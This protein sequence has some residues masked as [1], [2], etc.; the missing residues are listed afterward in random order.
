LLIIT[1]LRRLRHYL[2]MVI[3]L[4]RRRSR[5]TYLHHLIC[6]LECE[7]DK[8]NNCIPSIH[9]YLYFIRH[10]WIL[11]ILVIH[12]YLRLARRWRRERMITNHRGQYC[13]S[14][15]KLSSPHAP[16]LALLALDC[17]ARVPS[18]LKRLSSSSTW[19]HHPKDLPHNRHITVTTFDTHI[20]DTIEDFYKIH[21]TFQNW[22]L[23]T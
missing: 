22:C 4:T 5:R 14:P 21:F 17:Y 20:G 18:N 15:P 1:D 16:I 7:K 19:T 3:L 23:T 10:I 13:D 8:D 12:W 2:R 9:L 6:E 11:T